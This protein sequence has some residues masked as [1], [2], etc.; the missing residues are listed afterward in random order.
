MP[1]NVSEGI[2]P[3]DSGGSECVTASEV[4]L[5]LKSGQYYSKILFK[6]PTKRKEVVICPDCGKESKEG[7][8]SLNYMHLI[9]LKL[10]LGAIKLEIVK[11]IFA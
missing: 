8:K 3:G 9:F 7:K 2:D 1:L 5:R 6:R 10:M 11:K 4:E